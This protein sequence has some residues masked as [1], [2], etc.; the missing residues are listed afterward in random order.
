MK[1]LPSEEGLMTYSK[2]TL[3]KMCDIKDIKY[4]KSDTKKT[5]ANKLFSCTCDDGA[6]PPSATPSSSSSSSPSPSPSPSPSKSYKTSGT[7]SDCV[8]KLTSDSKLRS[9]EKADRLK[10]LFEQLN[11]KG[12]PRK[13]GD[14]A[15]YIC[16]SKQNKKCKAPNWKCD[17]DF[18][19][20]ISTK[21]FPNGEGVCL[22]KKFAESRSPH[23]TYVIP[24]TKT[25]VIGMPSVIAK[26]KKLYEKKSSTP[27]S[28][29]SSSS[30]THSRPSVKTS[31]FFSRTPDVHKTQTGSSIY[32]TP[33]YNGLT[34]EE[35]DNMKVNDLKTR[36]F[37]ATKSKLNISVNGWT[38]GEIIAY[39]CA[40]GQDNYCNPPDWSCKQDY[41]CDTS[42]T[43]G[44]CVRPKFADLQLGRKTN[45]ENKYD[46]MFLKGQKIIGK[47]EVIQLL[48]KQLEQ[49]S[50]S[51]SPTIQRRPSIYPSSPYQRSP[52]PTIQRP[53]YPSSPYHRSPSPAKAVL[54][55]D[56]PVKDVKPKAVA[57][58]LKTPAKA[59]VLSADTVLSADDP[60]KAL[61]KPKEAVL[62][63][64]T[65]VVKPK[66][67]VTQKV[68]IPAPEKVSETPR[69][70][71]RIVQEP[72]TPDYDPPETPD[73]PPETPLVTK[74]ELPKRIVQDPKTPEYDP[75]ETPDDPPKKELPPDGTPVTE[76]PVKATKKVTKKVPQGDLEDVLEEV[77]EDE[78]EHDGIENVLLLERELS[79]CLGVIPR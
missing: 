31:P 75:P 46:H 58:V 61:F 12:M 28:S 57:K 30:S 73:D 13:Q 78:G 69:T 3:M 45:G 49:S 41:V 74:K 38:K 22:P 20:D 23:Q 72:E 24:G 11:L 15:E 8:S 43:P 27:S 36:F 10:Q 51:P 52:S 66:A 64:D 17:S 76:K 47:P 9:K 32:N 21:D 14:Q 50:R 67:A 40:K 55:D 2:E 56:I 4:L 7:L 48:R 1:S 5:L 16:A 54:S 37:G 25:K 39:L 34:Y 19:C 42:R 63:D 68:K 44:V 6:T 71:K 79:D 59:A 60:V 35:L 53:I 33:C 62:S 26:L 70:P 29:T 18:V 65:P 77:Q